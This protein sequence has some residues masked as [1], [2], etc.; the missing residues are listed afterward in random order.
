MTQPTLADELLILPGE[1]K[2]VEKKLMAYA[3]KKSDLKYAI[4]SWENKAMLQVS[5][6]K[7][8]F[9]NEAARKAGFSELKGVDRAYQ[10][11]QKRFNETDVKEKEEQIEYNFVVNKFRALRKV[12]DLMV[13]KKLE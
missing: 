5:K 10:E 9:P 4:N 6:D 8:K 7:E 11:V 3:F 1:I 12:A 2:I 13:A